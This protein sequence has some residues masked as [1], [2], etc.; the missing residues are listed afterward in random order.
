MMTAPYYLAVDVGMSRTAAA[1]ARYGAD[2]A[3]H[4]D[5]FPLGRHLA[6]APTAVFVAEGELLFSD[7]AIR[8]G[9]VQPERLVREFTRRIGDDVPIRAGDQRFTPEQL[10]A[11]TVAWVV[12]TVSEREGREPSGVAVTVPLG[13]GDYRRELVRDALSREG[14]RDAVLFTEPEAAARHYVA[15]RPLARERVLALY[16]LGGGTFDAAVL[17]VG[18][19]HV[20]VLGQPQGLSS[21]G[22]ADLD[23]VVVRHA[24]QAAGLT[25]ADLGDDRESRMALTALRRECIEAKESLSFDSEAVIPVMLG[26]RSVTVR[27]T[28]SEFEDMIE[29]GI[30]DTV[31]ALAEAIA[32]SQVAP[33]EIEAVLLTGGSSR[34]PRIAQLLSE[35]FDRPIAVDSDPKAIMA[36]GA[37]RMCAEIATAREAAG[38]AASDSPSIGDPDRSTA[39][40]HGT[41]ARPPRQRRVLFGGSRPARDAA[42]DRPAAPEADREAP[43]DAVRE[44]PSRI[45]RIV[46]V[47]GIS[48]GALVLAGGIFVSQTLGDSGAPERT[49]PSVS[50]SPAVTVDDPAAGDPA[51]EAADTDPAPTTTNP[52]SPLL[53][54]APD[55]DVVVVFPRT[56][57]DGTDR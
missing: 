21:F 28:R 49:S 24:V 12:D 43:E 3:V 45:G 50:D 20:D 56:D 10:Y 53:T 6:S 41:S 51:D 29:A 47:A 2:R 17:R 5:G 4:V 19:G 25:A 55:N 22:G 42:A 1:T 27:L 52:S 54:P 8:R 9:I 26:G 44:R 46:T 40:H 33:A 30:V 31:D 32:G 37:A 15:E 11:R 18:N 48:A 14:W 16:D 57:A 36:L 38:D 7:A 39:H 35:R 23:D 34:I 13:W